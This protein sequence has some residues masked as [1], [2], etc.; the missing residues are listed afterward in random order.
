MERIATNSIYHWGKRMPRRIRQSGSALRK[1]IR[2]PAAAGV[3]A[4]SEAK[5]QV[6]FPPSPPEALQ[7]GG[8]I[9]TDF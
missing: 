2:S 5:G 1:L 7:H 6:R 9:E 3:M 8:L 4:G